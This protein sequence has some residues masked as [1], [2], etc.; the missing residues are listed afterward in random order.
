[1]RKNSNK[2]IPLFIR[3][4]RV[5]C[6]GQPYEPPQNKQEEETTV[7]P[8]TIN[9]CDVYSSKILDWL[10]TTNKDVPSSVL[11]QPMRQAA[12]NSKKQ[13]KK[14]TIQ[15]TRDPYLTEHR[16][17]DYRKS[18]QRR[19]SRR[20]R[21]IPTSSIGSQYS[22]HSARLNAA[23]FMNWVTSAPK[24]PNGNM[25]ILL[26]CRNKRETKNI[27]VQPSFN[28]PV[29]ITARKTAESLI[30][31]LLEGRR[32]NDQC[33]YFSTCQAQRS[34]VTLVKTCTTESR[35]T[36]S[37]QE[38]D[39]FHEA[40]DMEEPT[41]IYAET[42]EDRVHH[43]VSI[44][45]NAL[46]HFSSMLGRFTKVLKDEFTSSDENVKLDQLSKV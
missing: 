20:K 1:M 46:G 12:P 10:A 14:V 19:A 22:N 11:E 34:S 42:V 24:I 25:L 18:L 44:V 7:F 17:R 37:Q 2:I 5:L 31:D 9:V 28:D 4:K 3:N 15:D 40:I 32:R 36:T 43:V 39:N 30:L 33:E 13:K 16:S 41:F 27:G 38:R 35:I 23:D 21:E 8:M 26:D 29:R 6:K 45:F